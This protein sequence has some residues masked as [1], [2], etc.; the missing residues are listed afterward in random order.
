MEISIRFARESDAAD[1]VGIYNTYVS[2]TCI[3]FETESV[4][5]SEMAQRI[6]ETLASSLPWLVA[7]AS[8]QVIGYAYASKWK[9]RCAYRYSVEST[10]YLDPAHTGKGYGLL[11]Y[12]ALID[13][14]RACSMHA[15]IGGI[16]LPN[17][18][19]VGLHER[20]GFKKVAHFE[21]VGHKHGRWIDVGYWQLLLEAHTPLNSGV[22]KQGKRHE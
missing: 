11:L 10:V 9:G 14:I 2:G 17:V 6:A 15:V 13:A 20:L 19:S 8:G 5:A 18:S 21:Q 12:A 16:A 7:E 22:S 1:I 3:T 4:H